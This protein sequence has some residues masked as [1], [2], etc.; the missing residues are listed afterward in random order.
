MISIKDQHSNLHKLS[1]VVYQETIKM[2]GNS[3]LEWY[4]GIPPITRTYL[5]AVAVVAVL[6]VSSPPKSLILVYIL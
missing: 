4:W 2:E 1:I 5:T 3:P 6:C